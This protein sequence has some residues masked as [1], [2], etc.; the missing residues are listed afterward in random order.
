MTAMTLEPLAV[1]LRQEASGAV[2]V[3]DTRVLL[4]L[5]IHA[6]QDGATPEAIV[7]DYYDTLKLEDVYAVIA[8]YLTHREQIDRYLQQREE[9]AQ[10]VQQKIE[11]ASGT[12]R[13]RR[14]VGG[15]GAMSAGHS[16]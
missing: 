11:A 12:A 2:R 1:P 15:R 9:L 8:Y 6:W 5:V 3:G 7:S 14:T 10:Q 16:P 4:E 13:N